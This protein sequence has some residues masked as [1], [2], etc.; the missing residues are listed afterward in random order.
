M[1]LKKR[2]DIVISIILVILLLFLLYI[3]LSKLSFG[4]SEEDIELLGDVMRIEV[5]EIQMMPYKVS[6]DST[7]ELVFESENSEIA[8]IDS[9]GYV[10]GV[11]LG[12]TF[13]TVGFQDEEKNIKR[14]KVIVV[15]EK[16]EG[17]GEE[18]YIGGE[19][20]G[21]VDKPTDEDEE[22][23]KKK[24][25][26]KKKT[27]TTTTKATPKPICSLKVSKDGVVTATTNNAL[28]YSFD[29]NLGNNE[30]QK[31]VKDIGNKEIK[32]YEGWKYYKVY[33]YVEGQNN[34]KGSCSLV[35]IEKCNG[36]SCT[37]EAYN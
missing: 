16:E 9:Q 5:G 3:L 6:E 29:K 32:D 8:R 12:E 34:L 35:I 24:E 30:T 19:D 17:E 4:S 1:D 14:V 10:Y 22:L 20:P 7:K 11:K 15:K 33:Y 37:Y 25:E 28:K 2:I 18:K 13:V 26:E 27:T 21:K 36:G 31:H 23:K